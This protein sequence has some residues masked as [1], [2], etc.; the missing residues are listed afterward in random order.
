[1]ACRLPSASAIGTS[2]KHQAAVICG[3]GQRQ[4]FFALIG[5]AQQPDGKSLRRLDV[6]QR[7]P[8]GGIAEAAHSVADGDGIGGGNGRR[9]GGHLF[10][11]LAY[12]EDGVLR[13]KRPRGIVQKQAIGAVLLRGAQRSQGGAAA[14]GAAD[15]NA[16][17]LPAAGLPQPFRVFPVFLCND[18]IE[19]VNGRDG[20]KG[21]HGV[22][23][24]RPAA[25]GDKL[26]R[27]L[28]LK[29]GAGSGRQHG[30]RCFFGHGTS[31]LSEATVFNTT[32]SV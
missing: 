32:A 8:V 1:M 29:T 18:N 14:V 26:L 31:F 24:D 17:D 6:P 11:G 27:K 23:D 28:S 9:R 7:L 30:G 2:G 21:T 19:E 4:L 10:Q 25:E 13:D 22:V 20:G 16:R 15:Q 5:A 12:A 3:G